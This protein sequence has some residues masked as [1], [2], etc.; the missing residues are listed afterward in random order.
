MM[1]LFFRKYKYN[2][3]EKAPWRRM[4]NEFKKRPVTER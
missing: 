4:M 2:E 3:N 1:Q